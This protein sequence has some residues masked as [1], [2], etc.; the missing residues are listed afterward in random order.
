MK[1]ARIMK[2]KSTFPHVRRFFLNYLVAV[3]CVTLATLACERQQ[4]NSQNAVNLS[5]SNDQKSFPA[6]N[7]QDLEELKKF[8]HQDLLREIRARELEARIDLPAPVLER[9]NEEKLYQPELKAPKRNALLSGFATETL[10][11]ALLIQQTA[12]YGIDD[13]K[14][15]FNITDSTLRRSADAVVSLFHERNI[16][17]LEDGENSKI[18]KTVYGTEY[19]LCPREPFLTQPCSAF[20][21]G[22]L[23]ARDIIA[24]AGHCVDTPSKGTPPATSIRFVF[25]YRMRDPYNA[26]LIISNGEIYSGKEIVAKVYTT[27]GADWALVRLDREVVGHQPRPIRRSSKIPDEQGVY[28]IGHPCGLPAKFANNA[29]VRSNSDPDFF[30]ANLDSYGGNSG[31]PVF[32]RMTHEVEGLLVRGERDFVIKSLPELDSCQA[33]LVCPTTGCRGEDCVRTTLFAHLVP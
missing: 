22:V 25:G 3:L 15:I 14:E 11:E 1:T 17:P 8:S 24:T 6:P 12:V 31:S 26:Q 19:G 4:S 33:S 20:C 21:S 10:I 18:Y 2:A 27:T 13:R 32:N 30:V 16:I 29:T 5:N 23:V 9:L 7:A 28:I